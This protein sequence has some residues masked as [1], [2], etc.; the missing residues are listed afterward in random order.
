MAINFLIPLLKTKVYNFLHSKILYRFG[1]GASVQ[2][3]VWEKQYK[4][5]AWDF[6]FSEDEKEHYLAI[7]TQ[8]QNYTTN[9]KILDIGCGRGALYHYF[10]KSLSGDFS[11]TGID[12]SENAI[13]KATDQ[14]P[15]VDFKTINYDSET[16]DDRFDAVVFN[17]VFYYFIK[18]M[19]TLK[20]AFSENISAN[21][22]AIISMYEDATGKN[23]LLWNAIAEE[24]SILNEVTVSNTKGTTWTVKTIKR[25]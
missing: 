3:G 25:K 11:Y 19:K 24:Y 15:G 18:P 13:K 2:K 5:T 22:V 20:K 4:G 14:F 10:Q 8:L 17:E 7:I 1:Y 6:L 12:I 16:I 9:S 21:G 23:K